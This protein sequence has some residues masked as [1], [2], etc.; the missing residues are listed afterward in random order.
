MDRD[1]AIE[2]FKVPVP[3]LFAA[4]KRL[5]FAPFFKMGWLRCFEWGA[6]LCCFC[7]FL[8]MFTYMLP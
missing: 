4:S 1:P 2:I 6:G 3:V 5:R 7:F 8:K